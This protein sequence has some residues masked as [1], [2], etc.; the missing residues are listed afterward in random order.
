VTIAAGCKHTLIADTDLNAIEV[1]IGDEITHTD[2]K[3]LRLGGRNQR[4]RGQRPG[5]VSHGAML[6]STACKITFGV[7]HD[8]ELNTESRLTFRH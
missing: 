1:Q 3:G 4:K 5:G 6:L 8:Y 2:K 7:E